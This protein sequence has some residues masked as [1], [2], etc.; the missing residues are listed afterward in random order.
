MSETLHTLA[1]PSQLNRP[2]IGLPFAVLF[3]STIAAQLVSLAFGRINTELSFASM[4]LPSVLALSVITLPAIWIGLKLG[5][6]V[7]LGA[8]RLN[9]LLMAEPGSLKRFAEDAI[10]VA[11]LSVA[12]GGL[13][14]VIR[15]VSLAYLPPEIPAYGHRGVIGG[16][17]VSFGAAVA[18]EVW[19][20]LGLVTLLVWGLT[21]LRNKAT[22][23]PAIVWTV[24]V[25]CAVVF[26]MAHLPQ[27]IAYGAGSPIAIG[28]TVLGNTAVGLLYGWCYWQRGL[29]AAMLA[30]FSVD[31]VLHVLPAFWA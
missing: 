30:H 14:L 7:G 15:Q 10:L 9:A 19:F 17:A 3:V 22:P 31:F 24:I 18:E 26:G 5:P 8:P 6:S 25:A 27:L 13:L 11:V 29:L 2:R 28:G 1:D 20:R 4:V 23:S 12:L 21:R 16:L